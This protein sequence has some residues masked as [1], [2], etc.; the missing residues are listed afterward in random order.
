MVE[1]SEENQGIVGRIKAFFSGLGSEAS[2]VLPAG[3]PPL[4]LTEEGERIIEQRA[5]R[6]DNYIKEKA[7]SHGIG[8]IDRKIADFNRRFAENIRP[9]TES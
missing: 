1:L 2:Y 7:A 6:L 3:R 4:I 8:Y 9:E 5:Q